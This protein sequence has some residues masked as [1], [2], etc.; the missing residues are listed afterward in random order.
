MKMNSCK[1]FE[2]KLH[3]KESAIK[4]LG[5]KLKESNHVNWTTNVGKK[6]PNPS[7]FLWIQGA[8]KSLGGSVFPVIK[9]ILPK[10]KKK[11]KGKDTMIAQINTNRRRIK[12][13]SW[14]Q[15]WQLNKYA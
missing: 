7:K 4:S 14:T 2:Q 5:K 15:I 11:G 13:S 3:P 9:A 1:M 10:I 6:T 12:R 8:V